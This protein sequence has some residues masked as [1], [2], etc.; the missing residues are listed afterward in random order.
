MTK[1]MHVQKAVSHYPE[2]EYTEV[3]DMWAK[4]LD[5]VIKRKQKE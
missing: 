3:E 1:I 5:K 2:C 4:K